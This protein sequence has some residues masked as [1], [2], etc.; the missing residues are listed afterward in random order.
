MG[1][2]R[3]M[4]KYHLEE[5]LKVIGQVRTS[6]AGRTSRAGEQGM[7]TPPTW[8]SRGVFQELKEN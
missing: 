8:N 1:W 3:C 4:R 5:A 7:Q 6:G 2:D